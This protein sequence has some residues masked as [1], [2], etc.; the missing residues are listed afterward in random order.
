MASKTMFKTRPGMIVPESEITN[1]AGGNAY[2]LSPEATLAQYVATGTFNGTYYATA[3]DSLK[4]VMK[5]AAGVSPE[6]VAKVAVWVRTESFMKDT[7]AFLAAWLSQHGPDMLPKIFARVVDSPKMLR[8]FVQILRSGV[9]GRKSLGSRPKKLV[10][11][12]LASRTPEGIFKGSV[13]NDP[14]MADIIKM[15]HPKPDTDERRALYAY[16]TGRLD[17]T[18]VKE[19]VPTPT[20]EALPALVKAFEAWKKSKEGAPP[21]V[22]FEM[23]TA[24]DL[25]PKEW[26]EIARN[27]SWTQT[28][29][30]LNTFKR[31]DVFKDAAMVKL[32]AERLANADLIRKAKVFPYQIFAA[33]KHV[34][35]VPREIENALQD[36]AEV[37]IENV[38]EIPGKVWIFV[39]ISGSMRSPVTGHRIGSTSKVMC[40]EAAAV[41]AA[42][43]MRKNPSADIIPFH[44]D[45]VGFRANARDPVM[46]MVDKLVKLPSGGTNISAPLAHLNHRKEK[47]DLLVYVSDNESWVDAG[48]HRDG[49]ATMHEWSKFK[50]A[51]PKAKMVCIDLQPYASTQAKESQDIL[52]VGGFSDAVFDVVAAFAKGQSGSQHWVD[53]I[54]AVQLG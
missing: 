37:A 20:A 16:L 48:A 33:Y 35:G 17:S 29:M 7:P 14:S 28:R 3:S 40:L 50:I 49:T 25:G 6:F 41:F 31:H 44:N 26:T 46:T 15:V 42:A 36:A 53:A 34:E 8:N 9:V 27:A 13:G 22:P 4:S 19:G 5:A 10:L 11:K 43:L 39:D 18:K 32:I 45:V 52:N 38:P 51:N 30:N 54:Q 23:L 21:N 24:L 47:G 1:E 12:W 2:R